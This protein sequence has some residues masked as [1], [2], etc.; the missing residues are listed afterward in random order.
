MRFVAGYDLVQTNSTYKNPKG[1]SIAK[2]GNDF[3]GFTADSSGQSLGWISINHELNYKDDRLGDGDGKTAFRV[4]R[5]A[6]GKLEV[7]DQTLND[8]R[9]D[10]FFNVDFANTL[11]ETL[12][13][14]IFQ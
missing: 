11:G 9:S 4:K 7:M 14:R 12:C 5:L 2:E 6:C 13:E 10:K 1:R 8:G 3:I